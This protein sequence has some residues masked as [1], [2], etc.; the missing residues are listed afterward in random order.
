MSLARLRGLLLRYYYCYS[1]SS[2]R[3]LDIVFW[4][5]MD[6]LIWGFLTMYMM[7]VNNNVPGVFTFFIGAVI[8]WNVLYRAQQAVSVSFLED[9]WSRNFVNI[10]VAP[11]RTFEFVAATC[12]SGLVQSV[13]VSIIL[14]PLSYWFYHYNF[15]ALGICMIPFFINLILMGW[16]I[17]LITTA[18]II[19]WGHQAEALAWAIPFLIQPICA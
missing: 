3:I 10:F 11:V 16:T 13:C 15:G 1:R 17:G 9:V 14:I 18:L 5:V 7:K 8:M 12:I 19:R 2:F 6:L 4:P